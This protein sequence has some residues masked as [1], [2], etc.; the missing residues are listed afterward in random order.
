MEI[1]VP[2]QPYRH[3]NIGQVAG[4]YLQFEAVTL[5]GDLFVDPVGDPHIK[6]PGVAFYAPGHGVQG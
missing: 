4:V 6:W 1:G 2:A 5:L 3:G